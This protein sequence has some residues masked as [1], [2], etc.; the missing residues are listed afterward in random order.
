MPNKS[1]KPKASRPYMPGYGILDAKGGRGLLPWDWA[2][3]RLTRS[4]NY[5]VATTC[6]DGRP[7]CVPVWGVWMDGAFH[8]SSGAKSRKARNLAASPDC[9]ICPEDGIQA[10]SLEGRAVKVTDP[11][12]IRRFVETYNPKYQWDLKPET[13]LDMGPIFAVRPRKVIAVDAT[14]GKFQSSATRWLFD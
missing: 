3:E 13:V 4:R 8:F 14:P 2:V 5:W 12:I 11:K 7:H 6:P 1:A 9:V 10:V